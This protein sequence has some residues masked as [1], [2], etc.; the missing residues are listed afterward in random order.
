MDLTSTVV[1]DYVG[2]KPSYL[3]SCQEV[4][5]NV[6]ANYNY[7]ANVDAGPINDIDQLWNSNNPRSCLNPWTFRN[8]QLQLGRTNYNA[9][10]NRNG[11]G[12][13]G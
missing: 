3:E 8:A 11:E 5:S 4:E 1:L 9:N 2:L 13:K 12:K 7:N 6:N 10:Y